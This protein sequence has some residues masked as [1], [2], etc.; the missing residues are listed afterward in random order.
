MQGSFQ[1][2]NDSVERQVKTPLEIHLLK[3]KQFARSMIKT[4][5]ASRI[6]LPGNGSAKKP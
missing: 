5:A 3:L 2:K 1:K 6:D 4:T